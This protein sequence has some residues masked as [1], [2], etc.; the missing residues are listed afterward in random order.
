MIRFSKEKVLLL[1]KIMAESTS[2]S[3]RIRELIRP[4]F[5]TD[6]NAYFTP[7]QFTK[8]C[9]TLLTFTE[10]RA[11]SV[12]RQLNG[13]L[14]AKSALQA[15]EDKVDASGLSIADMGSLDSLK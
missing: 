7:E 14:A 12:R 15:E 3:V 2:E 8:A 1:H 6:P 9:R 13:E 11:E 5:E 4:A 10:L